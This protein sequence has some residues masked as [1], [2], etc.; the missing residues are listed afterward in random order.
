[1]TDRPNDSELDP[2]VV[3]GQAAAGASDPSRTDA[4]RAADASLVSLLAD[5]FKDESQQDNA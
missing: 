2:L 1:M 4:E 5:H 3:M